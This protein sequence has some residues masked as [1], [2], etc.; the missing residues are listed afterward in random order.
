MAL[1]REALKGYSIRQALSTAIEFSNGGKM[2][3]QGQAVGLSSCRWDPNYAPAAVV[4]DALRSEI[5]GDLQSML[6]G[7]EGSFLLPLP[8]DLQRAAIT[9]DNTGAQLVGDSLQSIVDALRPAPLLADL[10]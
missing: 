10:G 8:N 4:S 5:P 6:H 1:T 7:G 3:R 2:P 9:Q